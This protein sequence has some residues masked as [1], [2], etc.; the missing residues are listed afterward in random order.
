M[1]VCV[2]SFI[3]LSDRMDDDNN[4]PVWP[5]WAVGVVFVNVNIEIERDRENAYLV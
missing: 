2:R 1:A 3:I 4:K 5:T